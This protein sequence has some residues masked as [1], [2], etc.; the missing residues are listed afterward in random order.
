MVMKNYDQKEVREKSVCSAYTSTSYS[1][2]EGSQEN[3]KAG[4]D[5]QAMW[6]CCL[7]AGFS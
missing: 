4:A 5:L 6:E 3:L 1:I 7:L 2:T